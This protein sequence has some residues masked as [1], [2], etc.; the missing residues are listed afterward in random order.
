MCMLIFNSGG[1]VE[2][3][4]VAN[5]QPLLKTSMHMLVFN[6]GSVVEMV[7]VENKQRRGWRLLNI[8]K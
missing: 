3:V 1:V 5:E 6:G 4:V 2:E 7:V 8:K